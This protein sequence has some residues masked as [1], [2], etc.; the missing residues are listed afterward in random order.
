MHCY[1]Q[2]QM[3][4]PRPIYSQK[5]GDDPQDQIGSMGSTPTGIATPQ[6][7]PS[8]K[9]VPGIMPSF[10]AQ[11]GAGSI[12][13]QTL[14]LPPPP[15]YDLL[16]PPPPPPP[17]LL[18]LL[19]LLLLIPCLLPLVLPIIP[20][21]SIVVMMVWLLLGILASRPERHSSRKYYRML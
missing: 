1:N 5:H 4:N 6:P 21:G 8:D 17:L 15:V 7:D 13:L 14:P 3:A 18:L 2:L 11:V 19:L 9:R 20:Q 12:L 10:F 16:L